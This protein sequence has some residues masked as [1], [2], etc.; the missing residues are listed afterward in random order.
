MT[1]LA[2]LIAVLGTLIGLPILDPIVG[3]VIAFAIVGI[4]WN[5][6]KAV[7]YRLMDAVDP[8]LAEH[9]E[10]HIRALDGVEDAVWWREFCLISRG[11]IEKYFSAVITAAF[12]L[13]DPL[14]ALEAG[15]AE[16]PADC[17]MAREVRWALEVVGDIN[18]FR[19]ARAAVD[20]RYAGMHK[21]HT[22][23]NAVLTI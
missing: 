6:I 11:L 10:A 3:I 7:W 4:T 15:L 2:V 8:H 22:I 9:V 16:I 20:E 19:G 12:V 18:D 23:N 13:S 17:L 21:V 1:S 5:A 14:K